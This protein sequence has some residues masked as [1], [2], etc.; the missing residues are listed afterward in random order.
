MQLVAPHSWNL[1]WVK[2]IE[3]MQ[4]GPVS[5]YIYIGGITSSVYKL[6]SVS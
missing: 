4:N 6:Y 2:Q 3:R 1:R 5:E